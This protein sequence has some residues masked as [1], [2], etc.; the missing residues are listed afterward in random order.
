MKSNDQIVPCMV[1]MMPRFRGYASAEDEASDDWYADVP[2]ARKTSTPT[3]MSAYAVIISTGC[4]LK[5][6]PDSPC[7]HDTPPPPIASCDTHRL[8]R[9]MDVGDR[10]SEVMVAILWRRCKYVD[11][12][13]SRPSFC[14]DGA[15]DSSVEL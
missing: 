12:V 3:F 6:R 14:V 9:M 13:L 1:F 8:T 11:E 15:G 4:Q 7:F 5:T 10:I 2:E